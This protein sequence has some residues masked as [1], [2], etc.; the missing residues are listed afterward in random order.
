MHKTPDQEGIGYSNTGLARSPT[1]TVR[2]QSHL[3]FATRYA[4][5][6]LE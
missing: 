1:H 6:K 5:R 4:F 3:W 2:P